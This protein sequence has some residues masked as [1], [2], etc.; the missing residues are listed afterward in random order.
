MTE[1]KTLK[2]I[3]RKEIKKSKHDIYLSD[4]GKD[5]NKYVIK[6]NNLTCRWIERSI[7]VW[8]EKDGIP[9]FV[10]LLSR[11]EN[12]RSRMAKK[13]FEKGVKSW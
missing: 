8:S 12:E 2:D 10:K 13:L 11:M 1:L 5:S 9:D 6:G 7:L 3:E 4:E